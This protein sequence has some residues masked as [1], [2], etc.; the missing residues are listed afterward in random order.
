M[1]LWKLMS[2]WVFAFLIRMLGRAPAKRQTQ[3]PWILKSTHVPCLAALRANLSCYLLFLSVFSL[4]WSHISNNLILNPNK[5]SNRALKLINII[6]DFTLMKNFTL[7]TVDRQSPNESI[8]KK[9]SKSFLFSK[10]FL[11]IH[12]ANFFFK[13]NIFSMFWLK[14]LQAYVRCASLFLI[15]TFQGKMCSL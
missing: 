9:S 14:S 4:P 3:N 5:I 8:T 6:W 11:K 10:S 1:W 2:I 13:F 12:H 7:A 15:E